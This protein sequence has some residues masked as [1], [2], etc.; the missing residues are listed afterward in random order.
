M[1]MERIKLDLSHQALASSNGNMWGRP[2]SSSVEM[3]DSYTKKLWEKGHVVGDVC[4]Y[5]MVE[6]DPPLTWL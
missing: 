4:H 1:L 3:A 5:V 6:Q 2:Q